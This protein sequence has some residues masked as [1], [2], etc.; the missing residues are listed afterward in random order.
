MTTV[1][2]FLITVIISLLFMSCNLDINI[3]EGVKGNGNVSSESRAITGDFTEI[4]AQEGIDVYVTQ[5]KEYSIKVEADENVIDL[6]RTDIEG[7]SLRIH[8]DENI[9]RA[10]KKVYVSLPEITS[11]RSSSGADL[12]SQTVIEA[13]DLIITASS[14][15]DIKAEISC[16]SLEANCS[17]GADIR[18][19][20]EAAYADVDA[21]SGSD[22]RARN[23]QTQTCK[24]EASSGADVKISVSDK[25][26]AR[27]SSG[28]DV[29]YYGNPSVNKNKSVS[30]S[31]SKG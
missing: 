8:A 24:A 21:S 15:S 22:I 14:G 4:K 28:G 2:K 31:V 17:S 5:A 7:E 3:G 6:I 30:G 27:A 1:A 29:R 23:L 16:K 9:G 20:G 13:D 26:E 19:S 25:L 10:T 11:L 12:V 18:L